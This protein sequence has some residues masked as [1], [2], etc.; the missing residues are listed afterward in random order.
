MILRLVGQVLCASILVSPVL[1]QGTDTTVRVSPGTRLRIDVDAGKIEVHVWDH[2]AVQIHGVHEASTAIHTSLVAGLFQVSVTGRGVAE[3]VCTLTVPR[4]MALTLGGG[5]TEIS[6][7]GAQSDVVARN[8]S[9]KITIDGGRGKISAESTL[10]EVTVSNVRGRVTTKSLH[11]PIR[12]SDVDGD[13]EAEGSSSHVYLTRITSHSVSA[14]TVGG[15]VNF[16]GRFFDDGHYNFA[17][18]MGSIVMTVPK[19]VNARVN[20]STVSGAFSSAL[21]FTRQEGQRR[22]RFI[23]VFGSGAATVEAQTFAGGIRVG[24]P[25]RPESDD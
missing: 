21:P 12:V 15:H 5:D 6:V 10:G 1:A 17:T 9:G 23:I 20:V 22:G 25:D 14:S 4:R 16:S 7:T 11:A 13:V 18:H 8:Y 3:C 19:P 2:D 24:T